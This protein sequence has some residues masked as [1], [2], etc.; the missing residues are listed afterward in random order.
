MQIV[1]ESNHLSCWIGNQDDCSRT[2]RRFAKQSALV[3]GKRINDGVSIDIY[4]SQV[5][6]GQDFLGKK[7][8]Q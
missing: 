4:P 5:N 2:I 6:F 3:S 8:G 1:S 7:K